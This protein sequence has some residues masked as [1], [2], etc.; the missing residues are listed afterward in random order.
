M[1]KQPDFADRRKKATQMGRV[2]RGQG[3]PFELT[4]AGSPQP[5]V[6][7]SSCPRCAGRGLVM[8]ADGRHVPCPRCRGSEAKS[9]GEPDPQGVSGVADGRS[10]RE[11]DHMRRF[12]LEHDYLAEARRH[13]VLAARERHTERNGR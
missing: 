13:L 4:Q 7:T 12:A 1:S 2:V 11:L 3:G 6:G 9:D 10:A 8:G 5:P